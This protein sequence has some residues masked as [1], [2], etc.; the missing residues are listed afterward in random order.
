MFKLRCRGRI[1]KP[2][3]P[4][5][6]SDSRGSQQLSG[7]QRTYEY[8]SHNIDALKA[9]LSTARFNAYLRRAGGNPSFAFELYLYNSRL[10]QSLLF[11]LS[12]AEVCLRNAVQS[13]LCESYGPQWHSS[14]E[15]RQS[16][17]NKF[18][19]SSFD[20]AVVRANSSA[21]GDG[22]AEADDVVAE[23]SFDFWSNLFRGWP[24]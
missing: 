10:S 2:V 13:V 20:R 7:S 1:A 4:F 8:N 6:C 5:D 24:R 23:L 12:V 18:N 11:P 3:G 21:G 17:L 9:T 16:L 22:Q 14:V 15:F 19:T